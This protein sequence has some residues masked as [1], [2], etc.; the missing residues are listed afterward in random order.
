MSSYTRLNITFQCMHDV[1]YFRFP[2]DMKTYGIDKQFLWGNSLLVTPV[3][4]PGVEYVVGYFPKGLWYDFYTVSLACKKTLAGNPTGCFDF[5]VAQ[6]QF[7]NAEL[8]VHL[9][10][11]F[12]TRRVIH[13]LAV[14]R[15]SNFTLRWIK[16]T[17]TSERVPSFLHRLQSIIYT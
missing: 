12:A 2:T 17:C 1:S 3:L 10:F 13:W 7:S 9:W 16:S 5:A 4:E 14:G 15:R 6:G 8:D 11:G